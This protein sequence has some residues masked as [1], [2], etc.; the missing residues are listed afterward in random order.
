VSKREE[1]D[2]WVT[3]LNRAA[4]LRVD[5]LWEFETEEEF[6]RGRYASV[7][8]A[9]RKDE[10][11]FEQKDQEPKAAPT[12]VLQRCS[13]A[14]KIV[15]KNE[16]WRRVVKGRERADTLVRELSVQSTLTAK[17][18]QIPT[19]LK[20]RSFFETSDNV[21]LE[22]ELLEGTDL[23]D[24]I[25]QKGM[26]KEE[27]AALITQDILQSLEAMNRVG[28]AH[29]DLKPAN[30]LMC[31]REK[32]NVSVK[33]GDFGMSTF[34][35]VDGL[36]RGRCGTPGYVAPEILTASSG[37]GYGNKVDVF[38][39]GVILYVMLCGYEPYYGESEKDLVDANKLA[40]VDFP[41][42][43]WRRVSQE[44]RDLIR[45]MLK[46]DPKKRITAKDALEHPWIVTFGTKAIESS[47]NGSG[48][49]K[50]IHLPPSDVPDAGACIIA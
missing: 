36:V 40:I 6:G 15:D 25:S 41:E 32:D 31:N 1:R 22:L 3:C 8:P 50:S 20:L 34:V 5:D 49:N 38:S 30:I 18:G 28:M 29:R 37:V 39:A 42:S 43:D 4:R 24:Y 27:E 17:C 16:F 19:F 23:F 35:G 46:P 10:K 21:V 48:L 33:V 9:R 12:N 44:A 47:G 11:Y 13:C 14:L 45:Q 26:L 2:H 7:R